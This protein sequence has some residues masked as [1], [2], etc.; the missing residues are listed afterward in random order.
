MAAG[1][2]AAAAYTAPANEQDP[3]NGVGHAPQHVAVQFQQE[4]R[5]CQRRAFVAIHKGGVPISECSRMESQ[6]GG[7]SPSRCDGY[8]V[9]GIGV[10][11]PV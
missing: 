3:V 6:R 11:L 2:G 7:Q 8:L 1:R 5:S 4:P 9:F 10:R